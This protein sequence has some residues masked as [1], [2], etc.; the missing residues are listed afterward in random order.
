MKSYRLDVTVEPLEDGRFLAT[1]LNLRGAIAEG[2]TI[3]EAIENLEDGARIIIEHH[4]KEGWSL[5]DEFART[6]T[7]P[8]IEAK[9]IVTVGG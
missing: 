1:A 5:P 7:S 2:D 4:L 3:A 9:V 8:I 6:D